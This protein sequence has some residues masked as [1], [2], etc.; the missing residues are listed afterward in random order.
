VPLARGG[1]DDDDTVDPVVNFGGALQLAPSRPHLEGPDRYVK[2]GL[3]L[4]DN[5]PQADQDSWCRPT[6]MIG[7]SIWGLIVR[8]VRSRRVTDSVT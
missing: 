4:E 6:A 1:R 5:S 2:A 8:M 3:P 7:G